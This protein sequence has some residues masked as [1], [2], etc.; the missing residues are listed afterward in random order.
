MRI[1]MA[2]MALAVMT[3]STNVALAA[4][5]SDETLSYCKTLSEMAGSIMKN[6]QDEVPMAEMTKVIAGGEPDL[7]AL[8][9]VIIKDA[10]STSAFRTAE[11]QK[12]AVSEFQEKWFS[13]CLKV[14]DK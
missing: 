13:L 7:A 12:R 1:L 8:G 5:P 4:K 14:R 10:Y 3:L 6:R 11:D 9:A 2:G